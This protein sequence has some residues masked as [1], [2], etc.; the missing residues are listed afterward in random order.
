MR[1]DSNGLAFLSREEGLR[2]TPYNDSAG[3]ATIGVGHLIHHG[4]VTARDLQRYRG[5]TR[6]DALK[7]LKADVVSR[8]QAVERLVRV[9]L[10]QNEFN[11]L[12]SL[13]FNIGVGGFAGSTVLRKLNAGDRRGAADAFLMWKVGGPGLIFR[14]RRERE[15]FL[16]GGAK[17]A[18]A[19]VRLGKT[20]RRWCEEYD[21]LARMKRNEKRVARIRALRRAMARQATAIRQ[22]ADGESG[23]WDKENRR[24]R[25]AELQKRATP[26]RRKPPQQTTRVTR[27]ATTH[28]APPKVDWRARQRLLNKAVKRL[29][30]LDVE[31]VGVDGVPGPA[32]RKRIRELKHWLGYSAKKQTG[33]YDRAF[34]LR[35]KYP[36]SSKYSSEKMMTAAAQRR[37]K[38]ND[39]VR[40]SRA[41][42]KSATGV[43][44]FDGKPCAAW[45]VPYLQ[46]AREHGWRGGL[47]SGYRSPAYS[48]KLCFGICG[49]PSCPGR[50]AGR[51]SNHTQHVKPNGAVDV[52]DYVTFARLM[53][54]CPLNPR[55]FNA[56]GAR[57]P[58]H[59]S[60]SGR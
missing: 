22:A 58:V 21:R 20:E 39:S 35:L 47:N 38:Q 41:R 23:G 32:T 15:M 44:S 45:L 59:F 28:E 52:S 9:P 53:R 56:L 37:R 54:S 6:A 30:L 27:R 40:E 10:S 50:C 48:E 55:I 4:P 19:T 51:S 57:D 42:A 25:F 2:T 1:L 34:H 46:W 11:A 13:V 36:Y 8:E 33:A 3:H 7:L 24:V 31:P 14:R 18:P 29:K 49:R 16:K 26:P 43:G 60:A 17:A 12:V 5:F